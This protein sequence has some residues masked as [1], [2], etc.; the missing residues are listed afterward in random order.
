MDILDHFQKMMEQKFSKTSNWWAHV[1]LVFTRVDYYP[2]LQFPANILSTKQSITDTLIPQIQSKYE[3]IS[4]P[5]YAF[6]SS[7]AP[8]CSF[9]KKALCDCFAAKKYHIDQMRTLKSRINSII[10]D[11]GGRWI[12]A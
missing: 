11:N 3:M 9:N 1:M 8:S 2:N 6:M 10:I 12:P 5:K 4:P 7:K